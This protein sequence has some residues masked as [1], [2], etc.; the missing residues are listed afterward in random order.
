MPAHSPV[1]S[2]RGVRATG[3]TRTARIGGRGAA[4][5]GA[6]LAATVL[7]VGPASAGTAVLT[8][9]AGAVA[10][11]ATLTSTLAS[12]TSAVLQVDATH[13]I[14]CTKAAL[15]VTV[16]SNP[17]SPGQAD[18]DITELTFSGCTLT[19][20]TGYTVQSI[21]ESGIG[22]AVVSDGTVLK[23]SVTAITEAVVLHGGLGS[24]NCD[25]G[26]TTSQSPIVGIIL[27]PGSGGSITFTNQPV[28]LLAG[29]SVCDP[30]ASVAT[31]NATFATPL[32]VTSPVTV[33]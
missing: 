2:I 23:V 19:G 14:T 7:A 1:R 32:D 11:G 33:N 29:T 30:S 20:W 18:L 15:E 10:V 12:A 8:T 17:V 27:N 26:N 6:A 5:L 9:S 28:H 13:S 16:G 21:T 24:L 31:F 4:G 22:T 3:A 25:F